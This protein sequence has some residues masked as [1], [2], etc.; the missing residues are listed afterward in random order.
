MRLIIFGLMLSMGFTQC[1]SKAIAEE[2]YK[3][4]R[5]NARIDRACA[6]VSQLKEDADAIDLQKAYDTAEENLK[7]EFKL[8]EVEL[9]EWCDL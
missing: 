9:G 8:K 5:T 6:P 1:I 4:K 2:S 3:H 7:I